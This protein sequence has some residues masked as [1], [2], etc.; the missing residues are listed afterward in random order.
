MEINEQM[1]DISL[2]ENLF[3]GNKTKI[4]WQEAI[5][6][7]GQ[8]RSLINMG[9]FPA[10]PEDT[11]GACASFLLVLP[12]LQHQLIQPNPTVL[13]RSW[14]KYHKST[15]SD[16]CRMNGMK[17]LRAGVHVLWE[18][19]TRLGGRKHGCGENKIQTLKGVCF[20][21]QV[22]KLSFPGYNEI[23]VPA[24]PRET[25]ARGDTLSGH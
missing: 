3:L 4:P 21:R 10:V 7:G 22:G 11:S 9:W 12:D 18:G 2:K 6:W 15:T 19:G 5:L 14:H 16:G 23:K 24:A 1:G 13:A 20:G 25:Q 8:S 17:W